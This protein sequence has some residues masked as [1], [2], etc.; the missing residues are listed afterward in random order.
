[1]FML[2]MGSEVEDEL[3]P[4]EG[5]GNENACIGSTRTLRCCCC[6]AATGDV[7]IAG[8]KKS[9][10]SEAAGVGALCE[11]PSKSSIEEVPGPKGSGSLANGSENGIGDTAVDDANGVNVVGCILIPGPGC[12]ATGAG[13]FQTLEDRE[14]PESM[15][16]RRLGSSVREKEDAG[17][18][19]DSGFEWE[20]EPPLR[21]NTSSWASSR[22]RLPSI[23]PS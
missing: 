1:M 20:L 5:G 18:C 9:P 19:A 8:L 10:I 3:K 16:S 4:L 22:V 2:L 21:V 12:T 23:I 17:S 13:V 11:G 7:S 14:V 6:I 15:K